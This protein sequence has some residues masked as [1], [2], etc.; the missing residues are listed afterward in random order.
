MAG[1]T[2]VIEGAGKAVRSYLYAAD[3]TAWLWAMLLRA[4]SGAIYNVGSEEDV[5]I[6]ELATRVAKLLGAPGVE[7]LAR[8]DPGWN[9][10]RYV[11]DTQKIRNE[12]GVVPTVGLDEAIVR[13]A[14]WNG[15]S[16]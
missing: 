7:I 1:K 13:T 11:P 10:G 15:W 9:P 5:S 4:P 2:I 12:L 16:E 8:E 14:R 3:L 6:A